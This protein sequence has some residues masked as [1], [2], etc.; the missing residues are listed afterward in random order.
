MEAVANFFESQRGSPE[1]FWA[2]MDTLRA[3]CPLCSSPADW[4][5]AALAAVSVCQGLRAKEAVSIAFNDGIFT[6]RG[7]KG[8]A[9]R[10]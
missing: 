5:L 10:C 2:S 4:E 1:R 6:W 8:R 9:G 3:L 7:A